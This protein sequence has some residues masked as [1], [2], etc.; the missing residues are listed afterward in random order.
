MTEAKFTVVIPSYNRGNYIKK[1]IRSVLEQSYSHWKLLIIDDASTDD[2]LL[3]VEPFLKDERIRLIARSQNEGI[4]HVLNRALQEVD[5]PYFVQLDSDDWLSKDSL[6]EFHKAAKKHPGAALFYGNVL[7]WTKNKKDKWKVRKRIVHRPFRNKLQFLLYMTYML[8]PRCYLTDAL[9]QAGGWETSDPYGGRMME[10]R[11]MVV[12][13]MET[14]RVHWINRFLYNRR[15][16]ARQLTHHG[17][18]EARNELRKSLV[19]GSLKKWGNLY[20]PVFAKRNGLLIVKRLIP[21]K[22]KRVGD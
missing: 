22:K 1:A 21:L 14:H 5:T 16:H 20:K 4:S 3:Q 13:L 11:R 18:F 12:K 10:D 15:K 8:H 9:R 2:S 17:A 19:V 6:K 7:L